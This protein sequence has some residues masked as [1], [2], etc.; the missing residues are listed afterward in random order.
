MNLP[1]SF[2]NE[3][4]EIHDGV[5]KIYRTA[6][7]LVR[8]LD[9]IGKHA[10]TCD[11]LF[12]ADAKV[13]RIKLREQCE[14]LMFCDPLGHGKKAE[15]LLWRKVYYDVITIGKQLRKVGDDVARLCD[16]I[17]AGSGAYHHLLFRIQTEFEL[18]DG[19]SD[20]LSAS[21]CHKKMCF[22]AKLTSEW[23][24]TAEKNEW[25]RSALHRCLICLGDL[26]R[27]RQELFENAGP[28]VS[29]RFYSQAA[30]FLPSAGMPH[31]QLGTL[32]GGK[33]YGCDATYHYM[34]CL[35][36]A[37]SFEGSKGNLE[38]IFNKAN[39]LVTSNAHLSAK[40][41]SIKRCVGKFLNSSVQLER[42]CQEILADFYLWLSNDA[43]LD[44]LD[45]QLVFRM[46]VM[47]IM[48]TNHVSNGGSR[49]QSAAI[50]FSLALF[51]HLLHFI[52]L[53][54]QS[55][56][57]QSSKN[58]E[59]SPKH[60]GDANKKSHI[61]MKRLRRPRRSTG[62]NS[63][64]VDSDLSEDDANTD[65]ESDETT[66]DMSEIEEDNTSQD[67]DD[68]DE[69]VTNGND[70][71]S[72]IN[73]EKSK[74]RSN[75]NR[76]I[77]T[78]RDEL[79]KCLSSLEMLLMCLK[80]CSG[81]LKGQPDILEMCA[82]GCHLLC[83][84]LVSFLNLVAP[85]LSWQMKDGVFDSGVLLGLK[86]CKQGLEWHSLVPLVE[87]I[88][89]CGIPLF[90]DVNKGI[91]FESAHHV[92]INSQETVALRISCL[93]QFGLLLARS[94]TTGLNFNPISG[95]F[96]YK[97]NTDHKTA[98]TNRKGGLARNYSSSRP[99][100]AATNAGETNEKKK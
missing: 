22:E 93:H 16:H 86:M 33:N 2:S 67:S 98:E 66:T 75:K 24:Q 71:E 9:R 21:S 55:V 20:F 7:E 77:K 72:R 70:Q 31:N 61:N 100:N 59:N 48:C 50:A 73:G 5:K 6:A 85:V 88:S 69:G 28:E 95:E 32:A 45:D 49:N 18:K 40:E 37:Q 39:R 64:V 90:D 43:I 36:S 4:L 58:N 15:E 10:T 8:R 62:S 42:V 30:T 54:L 92:W 51:S 14:R 79:S 60:N 68:L 11:E 44:T 29:S 3:K 63:G 13:L 82:Q 19:A 17:N 78:P 65:D 81:W 57:S 83:A 38:R 89:V 87:D 23:K 46:V 52:V 47:A 99:N 74:C 96:H 94:D 27:Y 84:R 91:S 35:Y 80:L 25:A 12:T 76:V 41:N 26:A 53:R 34:R 1:D 97:A 56:L